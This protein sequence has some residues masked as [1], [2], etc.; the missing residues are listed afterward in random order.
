MSGRQSHVIPSRADGEGPRNCKCPPPGTKVT[1]FS[2]GRSLVV[3]ATRDDS[4]NGDARCQL[5]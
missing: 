4:R 2:G 3:C 5:V 1:Q